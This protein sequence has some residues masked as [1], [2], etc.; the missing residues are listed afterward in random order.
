MG[1]F[2]PNSP[3]LRGSELRP[4]TARD[5]L[6]NASNRGVLMR[7]KPGAV[8]IDRVDAYLK[9]VYG[10]PGLGVEILDTVAPTITQEVHFPGTDTGATTTGWSKSSGAAGFYTYIDDQYDASDYLYNTGY[11]FFGQSL[12]L[13]F[14]G[15]DTALTSKR[16]DRVTVFAVV[17]FSSGL[18]S[19]NVVRLRARL[20]LGGT[21]YY[22]PGTLVASTGASQAVNIGSWELNPSTLVPWTQAQVNTLISTTA[23]DEWGVTV[24][25][26]VIA[27]ASFRVEGLYMRVDTCPENRKASY[28]TAG[29]SRSGWS[30]LTLSGA[31]G[32]S[33]NTWYYLHAYPVLGSAA[34]GLVV[35]TITDPNFV[36][37][38]AATV[39]TAEH[40]KMSVTSLSSASGVI[41]SKSDAAGTLIPALLEVSPTVQSQSQP[42][43][44]L[45]TLT[46]VAGAT[47]V[48]QEITTAAST[49]YGGV[50]LPV[51]WAD[52]S[53]KPD[54]ALL[55]EVR[56]GGG[57]ISGGGTLRATA[58]LLPSAKP[59]AGFEDVL[60]RFA[61]SWTAAA[62]TQYF[63]CIRSTAVNGW[64]VAR[65]D[66][67]SDHI[68]SGAGTSA[69]DVQ[70]ASQG[71][72]TD[73]Y[74]AG[75]A[76]D[77]RYDIPIVLIASPTA[78]ASLSATAK[79]AA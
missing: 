8:T 57:A 75:G 22:S 20:N 67:R 64:K 53:K 33:A 23:S 35:P 1:D 73:S 14:R 32:L 6:L 44:L 19:S 38:S 54:Q 16:I 18:F 30:E 45:D 56:D 49:A 5:L 13:L 48:G 61:A 40:R 76:D 66:T 9:A 43:A 10:N 70:G 2:N 4:I 79:V 31:S 58:T 29:I 72:T 21:D 74:F 26:G 3:T 17:K 28:Y 55:I 15:N 69:A 47:L 34:N 52:S 60:I 42:Y 68:G 62:T 24:D 37:A 59:N 12:S 39:T 11:L 7:F 63:L 71:G 27:T 78:P 36:E 46:I 77:D 50:R 41:T 25:S 51:A 65:L